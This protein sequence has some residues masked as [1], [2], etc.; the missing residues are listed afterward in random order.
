MSA[1]TYIILL[2][3]NALLM[4]S[5]TPDMMYAMVRGGVGVNIGEGSC[6]PCKHVKIQHNFQASNS[7]G[8]KAASCMFTGQ[9]PMK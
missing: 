5:Y 4:Q 9:L 3:G 2:C 6:F 1:W 8:K 7:A